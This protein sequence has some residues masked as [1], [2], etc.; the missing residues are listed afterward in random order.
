MSNNHDAH[1]KL[2]TKGDRVIYAWHHKQV[3][4][5]FNATIT[6]L[7]DNNQV[8]VWDKQS[9]REVICEGYGVLKIK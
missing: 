3:N 8:K 7:L 2:L 9:V 6:Q 5:L 1:D 4:L